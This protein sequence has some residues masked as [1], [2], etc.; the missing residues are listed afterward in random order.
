METI[1]ES[2]YRF[3][4]RRTFWSDTVNYCFEF[5]LWFKKEHKISNTT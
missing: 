5:F 4:R 2:G 1:V 3:V